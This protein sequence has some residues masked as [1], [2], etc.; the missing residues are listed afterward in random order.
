MIIVF[1]IITLSIYSTYS[2]FTLE[3]ESSDIV[4]IHTPSNLSI[5]L[6]SYE[7]Q[8]VNVPANSYITTDIDIYNNYNYDICY[9]IWYTIATKN[10]DSS[11]I[12]IYENTN[13][14]ITTSSTLSSVSNRRINLIIINDNNQD[15]KVNIGLANAENKE[16]C[17]LNIESD[18]LIITNTIDNPKVLTD[19]VINNTQPTNNE[20]GYLTYKDIEE[21]IILSNEKLYVS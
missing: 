12:K 5:L 15:V 3:S 1:G 10:I 14:S 11:R 17:E 20:E 2:I 13:E 4:S 6:D 8:Q 9:S 16:T 18:K 19:N 21:D 7:Y